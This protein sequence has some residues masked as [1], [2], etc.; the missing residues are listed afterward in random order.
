MSSP[1]LAV[2]RAMEIDVYRR[3]SLAVGAAPSEALPGRDR[4]GAPVSSAPSAEAAGAGDAAR[5]RLAAGRAA[6]SPAP[7]PVADQVVDAASDDGAAAAVASS[8][9][10]D[11]MDA[12]ALAAAI[13]DCTRCA[14]SESRTRTV[15]GVGGSQARLMFI[16][17]APGRD[18]DLQ[19]EPFV[20]RAGKLLDQ[21]LRAVGLRRDAVFITNILKCRP[22]GN[23][24]P[25]PEEVA[26]CRGYLLR[27]IALAQPELLVSVGRISA[28]T[29]LGTQQSIGRLR[30]RWHTMPETGL[31]LLVTYHPAYL[32]RQ[33]S[34]KR[35]S[36]EDL[37]MIQSRL[38][39]THD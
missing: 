2:L 29:L 30:G 38:R 18:E 24:D 16:G 39:S 27:Q 11:T 7:R 33:P 26:C 9:S 35:K 13:A 5:R 19:G 1:Q 21:M 28:Q 12:S 8:G 3:R 4:V 34:E 32:L 6:A 22:P 25:K 15:Y 10:V 17:E 14:L 36:W 23:R 20:G 31:P 37:K